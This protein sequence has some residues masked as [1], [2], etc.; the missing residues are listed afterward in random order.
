MLEQ[1]AVGAMEDAT[2]EI[3]TLRAEAGRLLFERKT[4]FDALRLAALELTYISEG[5]VKP[6]EVEKTL[7][8]IKEAL[9]KVLR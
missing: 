4:L 7:G 3:E 8:V 6:S 9:A 5:N 1:M 2:S